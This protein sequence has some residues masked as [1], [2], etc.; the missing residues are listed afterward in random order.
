[1]VV[2]NNRGRFH[3]VTNCHMGNGWVNMC[4]QNF[5]LLLKKYFAVFLKKFLP[6]F[7]S[8]MVTYY[9][10]CSSLSNI[11]AMKTNVLKLLP[12]FGITVQIFFWKFHFFKDN[13]SDNMYFISGV[14]PSN[15]MTSKNV[16]VLNSLPVC[17]C[18]CVNLIK[19]ISI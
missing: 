19:I 6:K 15:K 18:V 8:W 1:M 11:C 3:S 14:N 7:R 4:S 2:I 13:I 17:V 5:F 9:L 10:H 12:M 16:S